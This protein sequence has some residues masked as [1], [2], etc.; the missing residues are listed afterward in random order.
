[1]A[2]ALRDY[3]AEALDELRAN[4]GAGIR[5]QILV[6]GT[7]AGK[8]VI[9]A[10]MLGEA[11]RKE[12]RATL[13]VDRI[14]LIWQT[15]KTLDDF[16]IPHGVIQADHWRC[17][18]WQRIQVASIQTLARRGWPDDLDLLIIDECHSL[19]SDVTRRIDRRDT[20][21]IGLT[22]TPFTRGLGKH[23]QTAVS[24]TT[25]NRL[26]DDGFLVPFRVFAASE[27]DMT[28]AKTTAGEWTD[29]AAAE[30]GMA[31]VGDLVTEYLKHAHGRKFIAF[32]ATVAHC[33]EIQRQF[34]A[35][36]V[37]C[38]VCSYRT[39]DEARAA[40]T[41]EFR[42][43][44]SGIRGLISV[45]ALAKGFDIPDVGC[46]ILAR[47]LRK[48]FA[49]HI[50]MLGRGLRISPDTGKTECIVL[51]HS[52]NCLRFWDR[53]QDFFETGEVVLDDGKRQEKKPPKPD[54]SKAMK[55]PAC[56]YVHDAAPVCPAC[57][58]EYPRKKSTVTHRPGTLKELIASG[59]HHAMTRDLW[60]QVCGAAAARGKPKNW[61]LAKYKAMTGG[62]PQQRFE[63]TMP[64]PPSADVIGRIK[65]L[66]IRYQ[67]GRAKG[68]R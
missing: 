37:A 3:Q 63:D 40:M 44:D 42:K 41:A 12:K 13:V 19:Y 51:D 16:G 57:G 48:G 34:M 61:A 52:G 49:E 56:H 45:A 38:E 24:V 2:I 58:H 67:L 30:R 4:I 46:V 21:V 27:P 59:N 8:T 35:V 29:H 65:Y 18:P 9:A 14:S 32:G 6:L 36:G 17:Q 33:E 55:C 20:V 50:Q 23:Y 43:P 22:A 60:P 5:N 11:N 62:W 1:M 31:V 39:P 64:V 15:S 66:D 47:P 53:M 25:T 68:G 28:D 10:T 54:E 7:G 26:I